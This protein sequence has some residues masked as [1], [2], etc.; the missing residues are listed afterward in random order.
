MRAGFHTPK[1][2]QHEDALHKAQD[3][4]IYTET[5]L[6]RLKEACGTAQLPFDD[7]VEIGDMLKWAYS[8]LMN[9]EVI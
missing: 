9:D 3:F 1:A 8:D 5:W 4:I 2:V 6:D 7:E